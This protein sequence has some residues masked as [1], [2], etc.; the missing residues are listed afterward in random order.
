MHNCMGSLV[1]VRETSETGL[2][3]PGR[4]WPNAYHTIHTGATQNKAQQP[5]AAALNSYSKRAQVATA[6]GRVCVRMCHAC[7]APSPPCSSRASKQCSARRQIIQLGRRALARAPSAA[8][9][10]PAAK[11]GGRMSSLPDVV[12]TQFTHA[13]WYAVADDPAGGHSAQS[14]TQVK[15]RCT[16]RKWAY[17]PLDVP[18]GYPPGECQLQTGHSTVTWPATACPRPLQCCPA[19]CEPQFMVVVRHARESPRMPGAWPRRAVAFFSCTM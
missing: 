6:V 17:L 16:R 1:I 7:M 8:R 13:Y 5:A 3:I 19:P 15:N 2:C 14:P 11:T 10:L 18:C 9:T 4:M 12:T